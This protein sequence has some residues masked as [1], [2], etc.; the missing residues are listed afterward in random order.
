M[1]IKIEDQRSPGTN[2]ILIKVNSGQKGF[3]ES[4]ADKDITVIM[5]FPD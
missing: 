2:P 1:T 4:A 5:T 3:C